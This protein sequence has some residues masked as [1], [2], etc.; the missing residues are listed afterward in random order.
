MSERP[1]VDPRSLA[2]DACGTS[3][4]PAHPLQERQH[5]LH[6][7]AARPSGG[8]ARA[9]PPPHPRTRLR[10]QKRRAGSFAN[11][12]RPY[13]LPPTCAPRAERGCH[14]PPPGR[15]RHVAGVH[16]SFVGHH[17][18][19]RDIK[20]LSGGELQRFAIAAVAVQASDVYALAVTLNE[21]ATGTIPFSD[22]SKQFSRSSS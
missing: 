19:D 21:V 4:T 13:R 2:S 1:P 6:R 11:E 9:R 18:Q 15:G 16:N 20:V 5:H 12:L 8:P 14:H 22:C 3:C 7:G 17:L 10:C